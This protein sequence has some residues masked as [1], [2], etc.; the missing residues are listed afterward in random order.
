MDAN[1]GD[2]DMVKPNVKVPKRPLEGVDE[3]AD[4]LSTRTVGVRP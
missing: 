2:R 3:L 4:E 1:D